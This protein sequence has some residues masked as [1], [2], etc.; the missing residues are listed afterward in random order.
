MN[1]QQEVIESFWN[2]AWNSEFT[3]LEW[4]GHLSFDQGIAVQLEIGDRYEAHGVRRYGWKVAATNK[5]VQTQLGVSEPAFGT[6]VEKNVLWSGASLA[7]AGLAKPHVECELAF[8][9]N[10]KIKFSETVDDVADSVNFVY[11]AF[12]YIEKRVSIMDLGLALADNAEHTG[13]VL[14]RPITPPS[15]FDYSNVVCTQTK[16]GE[17]VDSATGEAVLGN[18]LNSILWL[19]QALKKYGRELKEGDL[20]MTGSFLRQLVLTPGDVVKADFSDIGAVELRAVE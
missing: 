2:A 9:L 1:Q 3:P 19:K 18:P 6:L 13:I 16:N 8:R 11:P 7:V 12:E 5:A 17:R 20:V 4:A 15:G 10:G 14:G